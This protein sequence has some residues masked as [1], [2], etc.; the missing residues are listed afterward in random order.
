M[1]NS[2]FIS[3]R[4]PWVPRLAYSLGNV[5]E[6]I[7]SRA[8]ELFVLF[9]YTQ[10]LGLSGSVAGFGI[11]LAMI[12]DA[13]SDPLIGSYSDSLKSRWGRRH[14]LMLASAV[15]SGLFFVAL[16]APP[17]GLQGLALGAWLAFTAIGLRVSVAFFHIPWSTQIA[18]LSEEPKERVTLAVLRNI[19]GALASFAILAVAFDVFFAP[20]ELYPRGQENPEAYLPFAVAVGGAL[21]LLILLSA[22]G[23]YRRLRAIEGQQ[24]H[25]PLRFSFA[26]LWPAWR[27]LV[28]RFPSFRSLLLGSLFL[29]TAFSLFNAFALYL[30]T[31]FWELSGDQIKK[32]QFALII[33][34][35]ITFLLGKPIV[36]RVSLPLLF[37]G[38]ITVGVVL[39]AVPIM[40]RLVGI[41]P[42]D[43]DVA[44]LVLQVTNGMAG[45]ALGLVMIVSA[46]MASETADDFEHRTGRKAAA[47]LFGFIF[48]AMKTA[49]GLGKLIAGV[50][51]D[52]IDLPSA[53]N[54]DL[55]TASQ[56]NVLGW[57]C[58][59]TL[60]VLGTLGVLG[61]SGYRS[62]ERKATK[63][64]PGAT[65]AVANSGTVA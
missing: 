4:I 11:L 48:L 6:T 18:E 38:G 33:G 52:L 65:G 64:G 39:F 42:S 2:A 36:D 21:A 63:M 55:I 3:Q 43:P 7:L 17:S 35:A 28:F 19:F 44:L 54:A 8:F 29:L 47:M 60:L 40:L 53:Q 15:P 9:F 31:Y 16:F 13:L 37:R 25:Q 30:G 51:I 5:A 23:T 45:F 22:A 1:S 49:S 10:V 27:D 41:L 57:S 26:G 61:F 32:W 58:A 24:T 56:M 46:V 59:I 14:S 50:T 20:T 62:P 12:A 34:A